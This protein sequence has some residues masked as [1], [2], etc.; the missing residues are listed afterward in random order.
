VRAIAHDLGLPV[1]S[2]EVHAV[3]QL[4]SD[5]RQA[6]SK[7]DPTSVSHKAASLQHA[8]TALGPHEAAAVQEHARKELATV[9]DAPPTVDAGTPK[10]GQ[11]TDTTPTTDPPAP[12]DTTHPPTTEP[13]PTDP[14]T[15]LPAEEP[16]PTSAE[17]ASNG[18]A[19]S[20]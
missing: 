18:P 12:T 1:V 9:G 7:G 8:L 16:A 15:T 3:E 6:R 20:P 17:P 10:D 11:P 4:T 5:L 14:P 2:P 13:P 19:P